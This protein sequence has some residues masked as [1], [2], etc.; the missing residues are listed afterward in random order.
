MI[1]RAKISALRASGVRCLLTFLSQM[2]RLIEG[3]A[4]SSK[5]GNCISNTFT[6]TGILN[7]PI[8]H[9]EIEEIGP[10]DGKVTAHFVQS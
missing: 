4:Y 10:V 6:I 2:R 1:T 5:Y 8:N 9:G 3:G 7:D